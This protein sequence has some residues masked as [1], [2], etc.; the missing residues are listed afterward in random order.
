MISEYLKVWKLKFP[1][2]IFIFNSILNTRF[3][4]VNELVMRMNTTMFDLSL[5]FYDNVMFF[6]SHERLMASHL[7][8]VLAPRGNGVHITM[9]ATKIMQVS[10]ACSLAAYDQ[11]VAAVQRVWPLRRQFR[12]AAASYHSRRSR[13]LAAAGRGW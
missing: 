1:D 12:R 10:L 11:G 3:N 13:D 4:M 8:D 9:A 7:R 2:T 6:D 5:H